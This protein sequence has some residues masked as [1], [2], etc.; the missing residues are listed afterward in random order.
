MLNSTAESDRK[1]KSIQEYI[2]WVNGINNKKTKP[3]FIFRGQKDSS[4]ILESSAQRRLEMNGLVENGAFCNYHKR[5]IEEAKK[6]DLHKRNNH[7]ISDIQLLADLQHNEAAT[8][9]LD[10]SKNS[11]IALWFAC[12]G[13]GNNKDGKIFAINSKNKIF[14]IVN[15]TLVKKKITYFLSEERIW[16]WEPSNYITR[17]HDQQSVFLLSLPN[18][19][20]KVSFLEMKTVLVDRLYKENIRTKLLEISNIQEASLFTDLPGY[21]RQNGQN[22]PIENQNSYLD[23]YKKGLSFLKRNQ[24]KAALKFFQNLAKRYPKADL[25]I[26]QIYVETGEFE[27]AEKII[28]DL[29]NTNVG[30]YKDGYEIMIKHFLREL[31]Y[32][33]VKNYIDNILNKDPDEERF[34]FYK[35]RY[36]IDKGDIKDAK[37]FLED[38]PQLRKYL[39]DNDNSLLNNN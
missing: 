29:S 9:L 16:Y 36:Y 26:I 37:D 6:R 11:L 7:I 23:Q 1:I 22:I 5:I 12:G 33:K 25:E 10:F 32:P 39:N 19:S 35:F 4:W 18:F 2:D 13:T 21:A 38:H 24:I 8:G 31:N 15:T 34:L 20:E 27:K 14:K 17:I 28:D 30:L 3:R